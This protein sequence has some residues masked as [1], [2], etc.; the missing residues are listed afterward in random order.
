MMYACCVISVLLAMIWVGTIGVGQGAESKAAAVAKDAEE[1]QVEAPAAPEEGTLGE[2]A[3]PAPPAVSAEEM[4]KNVVERL[5]EARKDWLGRAR[6]ALGVESDDDWAKMEPLILRLEQ[7]ERIRDFM[8]QKGQV[9][10]YAQAVSAEEVMT[11]AEQMQQQFTSFNPDLPEADFK[12][13]SAAHAAL[14]GA[15][16]NKDATDK[17]LDEAITAWRVPAIGLEAKLDKAG[18]QLARIATPRQ[19]AGLV[20]MGMLKAA[21]IGLP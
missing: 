7:L 9:L 6:V 20:L 12:Q 1:L 11:G 2:A 5:A 8:R 16:H 17:Q 3:E 18:E 15:F 19:R 4:R 13:L 21:P 14:V 10:F